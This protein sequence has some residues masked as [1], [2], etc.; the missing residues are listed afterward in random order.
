MSLAD[1]L[2]DLPFETGCAL[3]RA[4]EAERD[5]AVEMLRDAYQH[6]ASRYVLRGTI[7]DFLD[8]VDAKGKP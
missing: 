6:L 4:L 3:V 7:G 8:R 5:E 1:E 2:L